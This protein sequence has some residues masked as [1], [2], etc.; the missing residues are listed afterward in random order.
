MILFVLA[1]GYMRR[2]QTAWVHAWGRSILFLFGVKV[3]VHGAER[4]TAPG[5]ALVLFNHAGLLDLM[6]LA[7]QW[8]QDSTVIYKREFHRIPV[9]G[10]VMRRLG[11]IAIDRHDRELA[12][13][14][15]EVA[16]ALVRSRQCKVFLAPE[17]TRSR[18][19]G[20]QEFKLGAF[21]LAVATRAP[22]LPTL[23][24]G[25]SQLNSS[26]SWLIRSGTVR[27]DYLEPVST[28]NWQEK[29]VREHAAE[30]RS[31]FLRY[32]PPAPTA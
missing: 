11:M 15:L 31:I 6:V 8:D 10:F 12:V 5:A 4:R 20:V 16:A 23:L 21:H 32:L 7:A 27:L 2:R 26:K 18:R 1:P 14:S 3:S 29:T 30:I 17:G 13:A 9:I 22:I 25:I 19:G 24:R 28:A